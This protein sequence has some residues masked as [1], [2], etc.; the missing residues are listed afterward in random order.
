MG[1]S[2]KTNQIEITDDYQ[3]FKSRVGLVDFYQD[4]EFLGFEMFGYSGV[5]FPDQVP[6]LTDF[7]AQNSEYHIVTITASGRYE[8]RFVPGKRLYLLASGDKN[9]NLVMYEFLRKSPA[10]FVEEGFAQALAIL[11][12]VD[13]SDESE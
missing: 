10:L 13:G 3:Y 5:F 2:A 1:A 11:A 9:P 12:Q 7:I 6:E 4:L 8:N